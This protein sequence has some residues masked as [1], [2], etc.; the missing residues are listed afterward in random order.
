MLIMKNSI[1]SKYRIRCLAIL[2]LAASLVC[3][4]SSAQTHADAT[5]LSRTG[6]SESSQP[7]D[8]GTA[9]QTDQIIQLLHEKPELV[10]E[11]KRVAVDK[12]NAQ[13]MSVQEDSITDE[14]LFSRISTDPQFRSSITV[15]LRARGYL[16]DADLQA[17]RL[18]AAD[19]DE[20]TVT[21]YTLS[22]QALASLPPDAYDSADQSASAARDLPLPVADV[23][24]DYPISKPKAPI[25][26][27][28]PLPSDATDANDAG[29][30]KVLHRPAPF[31]LMAMRDLY[32]QVPAPTSSLR[33]FGSDVFL[34]RGMSNK[35]TALDMPVGPDYVLGPGDG[36]NIDLWGGL[37]QRFTKTIDREG[38][39]VLPEV[40]PVVLAGLTLG[41]AKTMI[42]NA[43]GTQFRNARVEVTVTRMRTIR[44]YVVGDV[45]RPGAY[46]LNSLS[47]PINALYAAGGPTAIGSLRIVR[48]L[49]GKQ[50]VR[51]VD[52]YDFFLHG[53]RPDSER[54]QPGDTILVP[55]AGAQITVAGMV[56]R[57]AIYELKN[58]T[59]LSQ[60]LDL[61]GGLLVSA[62]MGQIKVERIEA[63]ENRVTVSVNFPEG[64][65]PESLRHSLASFVVQDGDHVM[66]APILPYSERAI[67]LEGHVVRPGKYPYRDEM[68]LTDVIH[69]YQDL[70]PEPAERAVL[71]R[72]RPPDYR[73]E[74]IEFALSEA[75]IGNDPIHLQPF[76]TVRVYSRYEID[77]PKVK[78]EGEIAEPGSYPLP[79]GMTAAQ[80]VRMAGG[81]KRSALLTEADLVSYQIKGGKSIVSQS[82]YHQYRPRGRRQRFEC[83]CN[84]QTRRHS[85]HSSTRGMER[86]RRDD[87][88]GG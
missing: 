18:R 44:I 40:G 79:E 86:H 65:N 66:V 27:T 47:T 68:T 78:I 26:G 13:G 22:K 55:P 35:E 71:M 69:S 12:L 42:Q 58:E 62:A 41:Q 87:D 11:L 57:P 37:S 70:L 7:V 16:S 59:Q 76:D 28:R 49:R 34:G 3:Q 52:L 43:L 85:H 25:R 24:R 2:L 73:P 6:E 36:V 19:P 77:P 63:H 29:A 14:M 39:I 72:L 53:V 45:Q 5:S 46:D 20:D 83:G 82:N 74:T 88:L 50:L 1:D 15:W 10:V 84:P 30:S 48:H 32:S 54:L 64:G 4:P 17:A 33:R 31:N 81:F 38:T 21:E 9:L 60:V 56:K 61:A 23:R 75:L 80:L 51:E 8:A 67:Y